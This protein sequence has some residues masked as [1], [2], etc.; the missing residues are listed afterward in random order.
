MASRHTDPDISSSTI[1]ID[2]DHGRKNIHIRRSTNITTQDHPVVVLVPGLGLGCLTF[3]TI[4]SEL[5]KSGIASFTYDRLGIG[6]SSSL[7]LL[8]STD[9]DSEKK[10]PKPR[11]ASA[12]AQE[13]DAVLHAAALKSPFVFITH[14]AG[15]LT[16]WEYTA[17]HSEN[18]AGV[19]FLDANSPR[20]IE[21]AVM[22]PDLEFL[23]D[24]IKGGLDYCSVIGLDDAHHMSG[25]E[26]EELNG[27]R[28]PP[29]GWTKGENGGWAEMLGWHDSCR[30]LA[31][32]DLVSKHPLGDRPVTVIKGFSERDIR[33]AIAYSEAKGGGTNEQREELL[34]KMEGCDVLE[35]ECQR[36]HLMLTGTGERRFV[37]AHS[38]G[39][40]PHI[41]EQDQVVSEIERMVRLVRRNGK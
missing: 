31:R 1:E 37:F 18:S 17:A 10:T 23:A 32:H 4:Q 26:W 7:P 34:R 39:H 40:Y 35:E 2:T 11:T 16:I 20:S 15:G 13:L 8:E 22:D 19:V 24:G 36:E 33:K 41:T 21:R 29:E 14:S 27:Q 30:D 5:A 3:T 28:D 6:R 9:R 38:S 25:A 12:L